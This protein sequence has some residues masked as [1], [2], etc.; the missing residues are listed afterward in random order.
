M[1]NFKIKTPK[2]D[3][4]GVNM[5][6]LISGIILIVLIAAVSYADPQITSI[7]LTEAAIVGPIGT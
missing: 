4:A 6:K 5:K 2:T 7:N 3:I 1:K